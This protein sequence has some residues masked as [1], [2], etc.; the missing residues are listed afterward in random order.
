MAFDHILWLDL[1]TRSRVDLSKCG[2]Y[3]YR[4]CPDHRVLVA[5]YALDMA[6]PKAAII[7]PSGNLP[8]ELRNMLAD[9]RVQVRAHNAAFDRLQLKD[10]APP[11][12]R[13]FCTAAQARAIALPGKLEDL[14]RAVGATIR[15]DPRGMRLI[16]LLSI[17][18]AYG[19]FNDDPRLMQ[20]FADYCA[21]DIATMRACSMGLPEL[22]DDDLAAYHASERVN[23]RGLPIDT[24]LCRLAVQYAKVEA[25][26][27]A[28][29]VVELSA[30]ALRTVRGTKLTQW[31][32]ERLD[33]TLRKHM[34]VYRTQKTDMKQKGTGAGSTVGGPG[35]ESGRNRCY[36]GE[37]NAVTRMKVS[38]AVDIRA[39]LLDIAH[40]NPEAMAPEV[41]A[42]IEAAEAGSMMST[43]KFQTML[44]RTSADGRLRGAFVFN[45]AYQT[46]RFSSTGAQVHNFPREV[47]KDPEAVLAAMRRGE[48]LDGV[49]RT[50]KSMLRPAIAPRDGKVIVRADWNAVEARG[51]PWLVDTP[52]A[53]AYMAAFTEKGRD[54]Y[55]E[56]AVAAGLGPVRQPGKVVVLSLGY[57]GAEGA[58]ARMAKNY[59]VHIADREGVV[60]RWR[61]ANP[62]VAHKKHGW[63]A[64]LHQAAL[65]AMGNGGRVYHAGRVTLQLA[66][67]NLVM[68][69]P[70]GRQLHYPLAKVVDG[71]YGDEIQYLKASWKPKADAKAWPTARLWHGVQAE[72]ADQAICA[73]LLRESLVRAE[74]Q[75]IEVIG[76]VHD[77]VITEA[78]PGKA[79]NQ[80][81]ALSR[82]MLTTPAW[83]KGFPLKV[84]VDISARF[85]K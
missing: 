21:V 62:W 72:N 75:G 34:E 79:K 7:G 60:R 45:G 82:C 20:E 15:K 61:E 39:T 84:E 50:L 81:R 5:G 2:A 27:A 73:D 80:G 8:V 71:D 63:W 30:G 64:Q 3:L 11:I 31:V 41:V 40:E 14:G 19:R 4:D 52:Q 17:P 26:E 78:E 1:E 65:R 83:A 16:Q 49:L 24:E 32:H 38:L 59:G 48:P 76:H 77:E 58:L 23:D 74:K 56:Q 36:L 54:L 46:N 70:S 66:G 51:L 42:V 69:L 25:E 68:V 44:N 29:A 22:R 12:E 55:V 57:G 67:S 10:A 53:R 37:A 28:Q 33:P 85:R 47:A 6:Q 43:A 35:A 9:K 18:D 13:W